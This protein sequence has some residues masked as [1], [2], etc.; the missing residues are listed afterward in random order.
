MSKKKYRKSYTITDVNRYDT[1]VS[2]LEKVQAAG[3]EVDTATLDYNYSVGYYESVE[4]DIEVNYYLREGVAA[5][6]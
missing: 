2:M 4:I 3:G 6:D 1:L 5:G